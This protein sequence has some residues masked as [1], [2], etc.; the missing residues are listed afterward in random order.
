MATITPSA[1]TLEPLED[2]Q[3]TTDIS[4]PVWT[5]H[6]IGT[7]N[8][9]GFYTA[10]GANG[11]AIVEAAS[12]FWATFNA[13]KLTK[14]TDDSFTV[15]SNGTGFADAK[16]NLQL[17]ATDDFVEVEMWETSPFWV[18]LSDSGNSNFFGLYNGNIWERYSG[19]DTN[20]GACAVAVG[21]KIKIRRNS[22]GKLEFYKNNALLITSTNAFSGVSGLYLYLGLSASTATST[23]IKKPLVGGG[24]GITGYTF[25]QATVLIPL[26][27]LLPK[28][29]LELYCDAHL[30]EL[31]DGD[32]VSSFTDQS[33]NLRHLTASSS[34]PTYQT[35]ELNG[36]DIVRF[37]GSSNPLKNTANFT[38]ACGWIVAKFDGTSFSD[39]QGLLSDLFT[40]TILVSSNSETKFFDLEIDLFEFRSNDRI[41]PASDAPAPLNAFKIIFF[42][43]WRPI[44]VDGIQLGQQTTFTG[45]KFDGDVALLALYS[46]GFCESDIQKYSKVLAD[47]FDLELADVY[48]FVPDRDTAEI[49]EQSVN[50]YDPPEGERISEVLG[51]TKRAFQCKFTSR[52]SA[53]VKEMKIFHASHYAAA[54]AFL[55]RNYNLLPPEDIEGY[56]DSPY[57]LSG[58]V[59]I[60]NYGFD[61]REK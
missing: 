21:D 5:L 44:T 15:L 10:P 46:G 6:G 47:N 54:A 2:Q 17:G 60:Y 28:T 12:S 8:S 50:F 36:K 18:C 13:T 11:S 20:Y 16:A 42:R 59:G 38:V 26:P 19:A 48:P 52:R 22:A 37:S 27:L 45:R 24:G 14:N 35:N 61:F 49:S 57:Q 43:L 9:S 41:Y 25:A 1:V 29:N 31:T 55:L 32:N 40:Q 33:D 3:F 4:S 23:V 51:D 39:Y 56:I 30:L 53:E 34:Y 58:S 7:L